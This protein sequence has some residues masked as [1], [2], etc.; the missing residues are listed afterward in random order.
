MDNPSKFVKTKTIYSPYPY[1]IVAGLWLVGAFIFKYHKLPVLLM[2]GAVSIL[3][4]YLSK[5][6]FPPKTI[7]VVERNYEPA[8]SGN[9]DADLMLQE[10]YKALKRL[11]ELNDLIPH[12]RLS[13]L[14]D[15][16]EIAGLSIFEHI[17]AHPEKAPQIRRLINYYLPSTIKMMEMWNEM[18]AQDVK[19]DNIRSSM[20]RIE[21][22]METMVK[23]FEKQL[24]TLYFHTALDI[25]AE[26]DVLESM[27]AQEGIK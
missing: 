7:T 12:E 24:D 17:S 27:F 14:M 15:K 23:V 19:V 11:R 6:I 26:I 2:T 3:V 5:R 4:F 16:L 13:A 21:N 20:E 9:R 18:S 22:V 25:S 8:K 1:Y 10:G